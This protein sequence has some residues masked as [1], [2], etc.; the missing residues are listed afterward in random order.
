MKKKPRIHSLV[1]GGSKRVVNQVKRRVFTAER[2][3]GEKIEH[4][5][6]TATRGKEKLCDGPTEENAH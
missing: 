4:P 5:M 1:G 3:Q 6:I 2:R